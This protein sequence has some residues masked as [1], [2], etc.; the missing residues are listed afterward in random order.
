LLHFRFHN[1]IISFIYF[2][3][4]YV[5][6]MAGKIQPLNDEAWDLHVGELTEYRNKHGHCNVPQG[7]PENKPLA[8]WVYRVRKGFS[9]ATRTGARVRAQPG[10]RITSE[11]VNQLE[12]LG[13]VWNKND[14]DWEENLS[15]LIKYHRKKGH[16]NVPKAE[17][18]L[19][20][21]L[22][23]QRQKF[24]EFKDT[25]SSEGMTFYRFERLKRIGFPL[26][27]MR[28]RVPRKVNSSP[29]ARSPRERSPRARSP[30]ARSPRERS[31]SRSRS[32]SRSRSRSRS[33]S[34]SAS[35][36]LPTAK[37]HEKI[38]SAWI[39]G[40]ERPTFETGAPAKGNYQEIPSRRL[41]PANPYE[42]TTHAKGSAWI[43]GPAHDLE[44]IPID[45]LEEIPIDDLENLKDFED[46]FNK[47]GGSVDKKR[48]SKRKK[49]KSR[50]KSL[51]KKRKSKRK[52]RKS[53]RKK[54]K[55]KKQFH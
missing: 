39:G 7:W 25:G 55:S 42:S 19:N 40:P 35:D 21:W 52:K 33:L 12:D 31:R 38:Q 32:L 13:F 27:S 29:R 44:E 49:R 10:V 2:L 22:N 36:Y 14:A 16:Y 17:P 4:I 1:I 30:R 3:N 9:N 43:G 26:A 53:K 45:D 6:K 11:R 18:K 23:K 34:R 8:D 51:R 15:M 48:K 50:I 46:F 20:N 47:S 37:A 41:S 28:G 5:I 24:R 54:R